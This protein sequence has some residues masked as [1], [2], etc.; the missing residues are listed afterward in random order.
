MAE[1][2]KTVPWKLQILPAE[3]DQNHKHTEVPPK[4]YSRASAE[5]KFL[6]N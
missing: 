4:R 1:T 5:L 3:M 6:L 2:V